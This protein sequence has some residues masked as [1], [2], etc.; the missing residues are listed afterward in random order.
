M[1]AINILFYSM[2]AVQDSLSM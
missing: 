1:I 2:Y